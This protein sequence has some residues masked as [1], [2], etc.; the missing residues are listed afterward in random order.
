MPGANVDPPELYQYLVSHAVD[1]IVEKV[2]AHLRDG[3]L[4]SA[5]SAIKVSHS[6]CFHLSQLTKPPCRMMMILCEMLCSSGTQTQLHITCHV[7][8]I[9]K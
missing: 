2:M 7:Q 3:R 4:Q 8:S 6:W 5:P 1:E 9:E